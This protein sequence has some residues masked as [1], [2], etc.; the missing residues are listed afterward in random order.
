VNGIYLRVGLIKRKYF[1]IG[2]L[3][4]SLALAF[5]GCSGGCGGNNTS[6]PVIGQA[7]LGPLTNAGV[8]VY[9]E[10]DL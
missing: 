9:R 3:L 6:P 8:D 7:L 1:T 2:I 4:L 10:D 5:S